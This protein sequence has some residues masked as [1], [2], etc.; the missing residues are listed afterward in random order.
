MLEP[1]PQKSQRQ[2]MHHGHLP[3]PPAPGAAWLCWAPVS[4]RVL[5]PR[6]WEGWRDG[7]RALCVCLPDFTTPLRPSF[8]TSFTNSS[9]QTFLPRWGCC[10]DYRALLLITTY[11][12]LRLTVYFFFFFLNVISLEQKPCCQDKRKCPPT[13]SWW[14]QPV[15]LRLCS[16]ACADPRCAPGPP[17]Q[18]FLQCHHILRL[19]LLWR[20][21]PHTVLVI[22]GCSPH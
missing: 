20:P 22:C 7:L 1:E 10:Q 3:V 5:R 9:L 18:W 6:W 16:S 17:I 13:P 12:T 21:P 19:P 4:H 11:F 14:A 8:L 2:P 15:Q